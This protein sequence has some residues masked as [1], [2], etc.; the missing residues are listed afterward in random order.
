LVADVMARYY[1]PLI[2]KKLLTHSLESDSAAMIDANAFYSVV[3]NL[4]DNAVKFSSGREVHVDVVKKSGAVILKVT[5]NGP[6]VAK[7]DREQIFSRFF[8]SGNE[9]V[10]NTRG[11][12]LGL[13]ITSYIVTQHHGTVHVSDNP[14]GGAIFEVS[15]NAA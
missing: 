14:T 9:E 5:D 1:Q 2:D 11:T 15:I 12:G 3:T 7:Q 6:G 10:R 13:F 4:I 8:R